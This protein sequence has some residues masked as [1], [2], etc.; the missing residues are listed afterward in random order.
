MNA[1]NLDD[2]MTAAELFAWSHT[3][4]HATKA[5]RIELFGNSGKG[6]KLAAKALAN[7]AANKGTAMQ[8]RARGDIATAQM[9][10]SICERIYSDLPAFARW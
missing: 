6:T 2:S 4:G 7:Y 10:E 8:C 9:Y 5:Q 1:P 3:I